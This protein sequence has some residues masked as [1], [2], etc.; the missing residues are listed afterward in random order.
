MRF[1]STGSEELGA[2][3][4][5][6]KDRCGVG[7]DPAEPGRAALIAAAATQATRLTACAKARADVSQA[8]P[9]AGGAEDLG[10]PLSGVLRAMELIAQRVMP[11]GSNAVG[12]P[13]SLSDGLHAFREEVR[14][15]ELF[16]VTELL[17]AEVRLRC[18]APEAAMDS[19]RV[20][21]TD[22]A[23]KELEDGST[24]W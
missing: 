18:I 3:A 21:T 11:L 1:R 6:L 22:C 13:A 7:P 2:A 12:M 14:G 10:A 4:I 24:P 8:E 5:E 15:H 16:A 19:F 17:A 23:P 20:A 9:T